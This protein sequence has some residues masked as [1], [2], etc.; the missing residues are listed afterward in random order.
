MWG[1]RRGEEG[2]GV[3]GKESNIFYSCGSATQGLFRGD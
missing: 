2:G 1:G 3:K